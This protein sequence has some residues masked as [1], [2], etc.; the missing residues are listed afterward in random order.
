MAAMLDSKSTQRQTAVQRMAVSEST[1]R[2][3]V[4]LPPA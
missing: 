3:L 2:L 4:V 1:H